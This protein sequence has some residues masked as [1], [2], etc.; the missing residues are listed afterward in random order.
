MA[1]G[2]RAVA[3]ERPPHAAWPVVARR[4]ERAAGNGA[5]APAR[6]C[7]MPPD[8]GGPVKLGTLLLRDAVISLGQLETALRSQVLYGGKL[9]TNLVELGF[10][11]LDTLA[12]YLGRCTGVPVATKAMFDAAPADVVGA[13]DRDL[14]ELYAAFPLGPAAEAPDALAVALLD[15]TDDAAVDA[16]AAQLGRPIVPHIAPELRLYYY[17]EK[18]YGIERKA[19]FVRAG[20]RKS[21][22]DVGERRRAQPPQGIELPPAVRIEP[23]AR[24]TRPSAPPARVEPRATAD[25]LVASIDLA[26]TRDDVGNA[27]IDYAVGR[28]DAAAVFVVRDAN[29]I[30]WRVH[31]PGR[32]V[33]ASAFEQVSL[34]LGGA[35]ALQ[36]A[37]DSRTVYRGRAP[38]GGRP[39]ET[40]LWRALG[41]DGEPRELVVVPILIGPRV[42]QLIYGHTET[43]DHLDDRVVDELGRL[44]RAAAEAYARII[45]Q[46]KAA[47]PS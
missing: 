8:D 6:H 44:A 12:G 31:A 4:P 5:P 15:P 24:R 21:N 26:A 27:L 14:A 30:G 10:V 9:G 35:S 23:R 18:H 2:G 11:D 3:G 40:R 33:S 45:Q 32:P 37:H 47:D 36:A 41:V 38:T 13:F 16:L 22:Q 7:M 46:A 39:V 34:P 1:S 28:L 42:V 17:L 29:A 43:A 19:R 20:T 25:E